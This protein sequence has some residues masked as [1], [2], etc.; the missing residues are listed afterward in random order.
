MTATQTNLAPTMEATEWG[1]NGSSLKDKEIVNISEW[2]ARN[3][4]M[5]V[6]LMVNVNGN[7][8]VKMEAPNGNRGSAYFSKVIQELLAE[9]GLKGATK[10]EVTAAKE[11]A[12]QLAQTSGKSWQ[13]HYR[14]PG[15]K[16]RNLLEVVA[17]HVGYLDEEKTK[18]KDLYIGA[19]SG[20]G[21]DDWA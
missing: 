17:V 18:I 6:D 19:Q 21:V 10:E 12:K 1:L 3:G 9:A 4:K 15:D 20:G 7:F 8:Y 2:K 16:I 13:E 11:A 5:S 14:H